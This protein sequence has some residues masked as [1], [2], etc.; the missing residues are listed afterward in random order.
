MGS[1]S[2]P[3]SPARPSVFTWGGTDGELAT[4]PGGDN[5][6]FLGGFFFAVDFC[7]LVFF[8]RLRP[9]PATSA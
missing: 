4:P 5:R 1:E 3:R 6:G 2:T 9:I 7:F 8:P